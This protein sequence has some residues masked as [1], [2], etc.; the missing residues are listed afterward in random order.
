MSADSCPTCGETST[1]T[2]VA[3]L[4][5]LVEAPTNRN[6]DDQQSYRVCWTEDCPTVYHAESTDR[7]FTRGDV[8]VPV[9]FKLDDDAQP[10][11]LCYCFGVTKADIHYDLR[12]H[13]DTD[14]HEWVGS[15]G[16]RDLCKCTYK[17]PRGSCCLGVVNAAVEEAADDL[18][19]AGVDA[20]ATCGR[21]ACGTCADE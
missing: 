13:G 6:V 5:H 4:F 18:G 1:P 19:I 9:N 12:Q 2:D 3:T 10:Y 15:R 16:E 11:P 8:R 20:N 17:S 7:T 21:D 14:L